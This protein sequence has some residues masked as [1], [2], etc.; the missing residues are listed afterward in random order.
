M[1]RPNGKSGIFLSLCM[2]AALASLLPSQSCAVA[3]LESRI[4][5]V[6][7]PIASARRVEIDL[8]FTLSGDGQQVRVDRVLAADGGV[9]VLIAVD[10]E[11]G[12]QGPEVQ[13]RRLPLTLDNLPTGSY[14]L[15]LIA[16]EDTSQVLA[17][18]TITVAAAPP[19]PVPLPVRVWPPGASRMDSLWLLI[20]PPGF[21]DR[22]EPAPFIEAGVSLVIRHTPQACSGDPGPPRLHAVRLGS[23]QPQDT[24]KQ[25]WLPQT[26]DMTSADLVGALRFQVHDRLSPRLGGLW[27]NPDQS[28]H[29]ITLHMLPDG[30]VLLLWFVFDQ[31]GNPAWV[32]GLGGQSGQTA[33]L[34]ASFT[35]GG[36]FPPAFD[37]DAVVREFWGTIALEFSSCD[38]AVMRWQSSFPGFNDGEI[39][40]Q[41]LAGAA[42]H[43]CDGPPAD[44][45]LLPDWYQGPGSYFRLP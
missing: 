35:R 21:C 15:R 6:D 2:G 26:D 14:P 12:F 45:E 29:G 32:L 37:A 4:V 30:Q 9:N 10:L 36:R 20:E 38:S 18:T 42:E 22:F 31:S 28:G 13:L 39:A 33:S 16:A 41:R 24:L 19:A 23:S 17:T 8:E 25:L 5:S 40:L 44:S 43:D 3:P 27:F 34:D 1:D 11:G 7:Q